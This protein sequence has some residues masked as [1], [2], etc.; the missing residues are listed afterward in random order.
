MIL[1]VAVLYT[2][3]SISSRDPTSVFF[4][5][6]KG[7]A[8]RYSTVRRQQAEAFIAAYNYAKPTDITKASDDNKKRKLCVGIPSINRDGRRYLPAA[9]G[10]LLQ[11]LTTEERQEI[12]LMVFIPHS[13]PE[14]HSAYTEK[15]LPALVDEI[16]LY[17]FGPDHL[18]FVS[19][20]EQQGGRVDEK[21]LL[22][23]SYLLSKCAEEYTPYI[24]I[25]EDDTVAMDGWYHR[26]IAALHEAEQQTALHHSKLD[27]LFLRLF[28][29]EEYLGWNAE[30]WQTY[31]WHS[32]VVVAMSTAIL[33]F[34]RIC[35]PRTKFTVTLTTWR[36][37]LA[38]Y[39]SLAVVILFYFALGHNTVLP[40]PRGV[41]EMPQFGCCSQALVYPNHK[42]RELVAYL[43]DRRIGYLHTVMEDY[44]NENDELRFVVAPSLV[45]HVGR[46]SSKGVA[47]KIWSFAFER[48]GEQALRKEHEKITKLR[49]EA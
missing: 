40:M 42:T 8:P 11:G 33:V 24:A 13:K 2:I 21:G 47:E 34:I 25:F 32:V 37:F 46:E 26:T 6:R 49:N 17:D 27:F 1:A 18:Q 22:D 31:L 39:A 29:T 48:Y 36:A 15:W 7:Y 23:Y 44:A 41:Y 20:M 14:T 43:R 38:L 19:N 12:Y 9:L 16:L 45:Q 5:P 3:T 4:S 30:Y 10:S 28:Y 35:Q